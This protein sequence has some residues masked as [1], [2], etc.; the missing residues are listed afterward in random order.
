MWIVIL[1]YLLFSFDWISFFSG[2]YCCFMQLPCVK[3]AENPLKHKQT[4]EQQQQI[5]DITIYDYVGKCF[6]FV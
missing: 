5:F 6:V 1:G 2:Y 3:F 4:D